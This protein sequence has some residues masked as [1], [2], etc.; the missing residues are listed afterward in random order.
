M[1]GCRRHCTEEA[2][3]P[4][5]GFGRERCSYCCENGRLLVDVNVFVESRAAV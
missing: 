5:A 2:S 4:R 3:K 1:L